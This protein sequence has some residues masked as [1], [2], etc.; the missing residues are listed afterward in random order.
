MGFFSAVSPVLADLDRMGGTAA[1]N[2]WDDR[3]AEAIRGFSNAYGNGALL[4]SERTLIDYGALETQAAYVF[5]YVGGHADFLDQVLRRAEQEQMLARLRQQQI[6]VTSLGGGPGSDLLALVSFLRQLPAEERPRQIRYRV[7]DKQPNWHET[8]QRVADLQ[9]GTFEI[10]LVFQS[11]DVTV[12][13][14]W[15]GV[16][17]ANDD[18]LIMNFFVSKVCRLREHASVRGCLESIMRSLS[19]GGL[20]LFNDSAAYTFYSYFDDRVAAAGSFRALLRDNQRLDA[21]PNF[22]EL[23]R[24]S[25]VRFDRTPK[26]GSNAAFRVHEKK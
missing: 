8:L 13:A 4:Q 19:T 11:M 16:S 5:M 26:L 9:K 3:V 10:E 17:C 23:F 2:A 12:P 25:M 15:N 6:C 24:Q 20:L 1:G 14:Q 7:L 22:D 18:L 21:D